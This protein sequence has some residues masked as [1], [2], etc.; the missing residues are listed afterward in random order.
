MARKYE[1]VQLEQE[2]KLGGLFRPADHLR[3]PSGMSRK[4]NLINSF[5]TTCSL[6]RTDPLDSGW[7]YVR[8]LNMQKGPN[9][10]SER[11]LSRRA[12]KRRHQTTNIEIQRKRK[13][14][15]FPDRSII[16]SPH[17][18]AAG[19]AIFGQQVIHQRGRDEKNN[20]HT[21]FHA[22]NVIDAIFAPRTRSA[23]QKPRS[24]M[25]RPCNM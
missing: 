23:S 9:E 1:I 6:F 11:R 12:C 17:K 20:L 10:A 5:F 21:F 2:R 4:T 8:A 25:N 3:D 7:L 22:Y 14:K 16:F 18:M 13:K 24:G 15:S 19:V